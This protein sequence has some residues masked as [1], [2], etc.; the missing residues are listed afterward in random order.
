MSSVPGEA[1]IALGAA[2]G[3]LGLAIGWTTWSWWAVG[4]KLDKDQDEHGERF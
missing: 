1:V 3:V 4:R 2:A